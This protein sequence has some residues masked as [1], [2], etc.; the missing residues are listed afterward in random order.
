MYDADKFKGD[1]F[2]DWIDG[3][4]NAKKSTLTAGEALSQYKTHLESVGKTTSVTAKA[5][6]GLKSIGGTI[7]CRK[8][9]C[10]RTNRRSNQPSHQRYLQ[11]CQS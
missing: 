4:D 6:S 7:N 1:P 11:Y 9:D 5:M 2:K 3:L 8:Y 10:R